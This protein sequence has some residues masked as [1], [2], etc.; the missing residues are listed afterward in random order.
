LEPNQ[1]L[2]KLPQENSK[3]TNNF[4]IK[5][6]PCAQPSPTSTT[7]PL[8]PEETNSNWSLNWK[9]WLKPDLT[10]SRTKTTKETKEFPTKF[11]FLS[12]TQITK[13]KKKKKKKNFPSVPCCT[14][15]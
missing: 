6:K 13:F 3:E 10:K 15:R 4:G 2:P 9:R 8:K 5:L 11:D 14:L 12:H 1:P 7:L